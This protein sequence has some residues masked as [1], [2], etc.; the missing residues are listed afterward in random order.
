MKEKNNPLLPVFHPPQNPQSKTP[1]NAL[2]V[3]EILAWKLK[4]KFVLG[5]S[6]RVIREHT[7]MLQFWDSQTAGA[8]KGQQRIP[9]QDECPPETPPCSLIFRT[10]LKLEGNPQSCPAMGRSGSVVPWELES[11]SQQS[12][13]VGVG[14]EDK[15][16]FLQ[17]ARLLCSK[18]AG[19]HQP[20]CSTAC[21]AP[22]LPASPHPWPGA[23]SAVPSCPPTLSKFSRTQ[24]HLPF[25]YL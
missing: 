15:H 22:H 25:P 8:S 16:R 14:K 2:N 5:R 18:Q 17:K 9:P 4:F 10:E 7:N 21:F 6:Q 23:F 13:R 19:K 11:Q 12:R 20:W 24:L 3:L 1:E